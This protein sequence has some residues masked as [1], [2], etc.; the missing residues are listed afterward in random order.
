M[1]RNDLNISI[2]RW[3]F[4]SIIKITQPKENFNTSWNFI[5]NRKSLFLFQPQHYIFVFFFKHKNSRIVQQILKSI[6]AI[7]HLGREK[8]VVKIWRF[9]ILSLIN[10]AK[11]GEKVF[12]LPSLI[13]LARESALKKYFSF[14]AST[15]VKIQKRDITR[16]AVMPCSY[17][18][19]LSTKEK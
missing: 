7:C 1:L 18:I 16:P 10:F 14:K 15:Q 6:S 19:M 11:C 17:F 13:L 8:F 12:F 5:R 4:C 2:S 9:V 3:Y